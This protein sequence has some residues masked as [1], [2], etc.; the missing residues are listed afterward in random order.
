M[1]LA[2]DAAYDQLRAIAEGRDLRITTAAATDSVPVTSL[3]AWA[4]AQVQKVGAQNRIQLSRR[5]GAERVLA[6][7]S[8]GG[9]YLTH[10][11]GLRCSFEFVLIEQPGGAGIQSY[12][13]EL[14]PP[15][16][17][18]KAPAFLRWEYTP[19]RKEDVDAIREPLAHVHPGHD[20]VRL[21]APVH[22]VKE[23]ILM[24]THTDLWT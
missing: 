20:E 10:R 17:H 11:N 15:E 19:V 3:L 9:P 14:R 18:S 24:F 12:S 5:D 23:L 6:G 22:T 21:P 8:R 1:S 2:A 7:G 4:Q 16:D 13:M